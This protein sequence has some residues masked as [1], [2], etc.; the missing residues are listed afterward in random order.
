M[1]LKTYQQTALAQLEH[2]IAALKEARQTI[3]KVAAIAADQGADVPEEML[4]L[5]RVAWDKLK[6]RGLLPGIEQGGTPKVPDHISRTAASGASIPH[7]CLKVPTGGGKTLLGVAALERIC[8]DT[9][10]ILWIVPT[11]AI[12][13]Q[14]FLAFRTREHPYRQMLERTSGGKVKLLQK[15]DPFTQQDIDNY[16]CV[17]MLMLPAANRK[18]NREFLKI[19][20]DSS[21]YGSFFPEHDDQ[22]KNNDLVENH[23]DLDKSSNRPRQSLFNTLK[24]IRPVVIL[25][26]AHKAYGAKKP[27][28]N[29]EFVEAVNRLNPRFV[30]ELSATPKTG[31]S[32]ILADISGVDLQ[33]EEM[34]KELVE[35]NSLRNSDWKY[36]LTAAK[37]KLAQLESAARELHNKENRYIRPIALVRVERTGAKQRNKGKIHAEDALKYL[38]RQLAV[39][40]NQIRI[41]SSE[42][43]ELANED[44]LSEICE[45]RWIITKD[46]LKEGWDCAFAYVLALLD[47]TTAPTAMTQMVG[48]VMRLPHARHINNYPALNR[49]AIYCYNQDVGKAASQVKAGLQQE[50]L[51]GL[52]SSVYAHSDAG[53]T[54]QVPLTPRSQYRK[55]KIFLPCVLHRE[56]RKWRLLDYERDIL[57]AIH[58]DT[59]AAGK[60]SNLDPGDMP[61]TE[62]TTVSVGGQGEVSEKDSESHGQ[63]RVNFFTRRLYGVMPN[64]WQAARV[65]SIFLQEHRDAG[66]DDACL[67]A[68]RVDLS[69]ILCQN[70]SHHVED[71]A[72]RIFCGKVKRKE[73]KFHLKVDRTLNYVLNKTYEYYVSINAH[74][75][76]TSYGKQLQLN[77]FE[78]VY[79]SEFN[80]FEK[81]FALYLDGN[82][83]IR[84]WHKLAL[85]QQYALQ[86]WQRNRI[87]PDFVV[88]KKDNRLLVLEIKGMHLSGNP[89][90]TY[91]EK[92]L[93]VLEAAYATAFEGGDLE[94]KEPPAAF[95]IM[96]ADDWK[97]DLNKLLSEQ[98]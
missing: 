48:R 40:E 89:D 92:L 49:C 38:I 87:F 62:T 83:A 7:V 4:N 26:E 64:P 68:K 71:K 91:K 27:E 85:K 45:V 67:F 23:P 54:K 60:A 50:G 61:R 18:R 57:S 51:T 20:R 63:L 21:G 84:W 90:T 6:T 96:F 86:G 79:E 8:S 5:P 95:R 34:I 31:I 39:P 88:H 74:S 44:L 82:E 43:K 9:G 78:P 77:L 41:Q 53:E 98:V 97:N 93:A 56:G 47:N 17:M 35:I 58:W 33:R 14:T 46:A 11:K 73:I 10:F 36:A 25:D 22:I 70:I 3:E 59:I 42:R 2:Y 30:L 29:E 1:Q 55:P 81:E 66:Y 75:L 80:N 28:S 13:T 72:E 16:L 52:G 37:E 94:V 19:F 12:Y 69:A 24:L 65:A 15:L 76:E 32:N